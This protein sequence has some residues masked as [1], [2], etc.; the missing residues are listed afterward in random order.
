MKIIKNDETLRKNNSDKCEVIEY[1]F[2]DKNIDLGIAIITDRYPEKG[3]CVNLVCKELIYVIEGSGK[4]Y[5]ENKCVDFS[6]GDSIL[7]D[8]NE[9][10]YW[11]TKYCKVSMTCTPAFSVDQYKIVE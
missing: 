10:Y 9:K 2:E 4:L 8:K 11:D 5:F 1:S 7:I 3:Y 6:S